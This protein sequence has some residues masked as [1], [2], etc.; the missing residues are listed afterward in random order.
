MF[1]LYEQKNEKTAISISV[2]ISFCKYNL[3]SYDRL[4]NAE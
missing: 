1:E 4:W 3:I 2:N